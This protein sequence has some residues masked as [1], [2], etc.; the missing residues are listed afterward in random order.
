MTKVKETIKGFDF[1]TLIEFTRSGIAL[2]ADV[3][4]RNYL[5]NGGLNVPNTLEDILDI[6]IF[7]VMNATSE[8]RM[9]IKTTNCL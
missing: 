5:E 9:T 6:Q 3:L 2:N 7:S 4:L 1:E 8:N